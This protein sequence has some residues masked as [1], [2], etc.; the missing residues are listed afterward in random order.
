MSCSCKAMECPFSLC[1]HS[2]IQIFF[3]WA[4]LFLVKVSV[5]QSCPTLCHPMD[6]S[7]PG[8]SVHGIL[9]AR[10]LERVAMPFSE[11]PIFYLQQH[12]L[13]LSLQR[14]ERKH[15]SMCTKYYLGTYF[16][17]SSYPQIGKRTLCAK[18]ELLLFYNSLVI[19]LP[20]GMTFF[21]VW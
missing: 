4:V 6:C 19:W 21:I 13:Q 14:G 5:A 12:N 11:I 20:F 1:L 15:S 8:S 9:Q 2:Y 7:P 10:I 16:S 3:K 17:S 18:K